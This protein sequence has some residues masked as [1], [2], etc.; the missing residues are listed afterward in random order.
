LTSA[1][2]QPYKD[3]D[4][5][6]SMSPDPDTLR[7]RTKILGAYLREVRLNANETIEACA[8]F[9]GITPAEME[10]FELGEQAISLPELELLSY[11][12]KVPLDQLWERQDIKAGNGEKEAM[13]VASLIHL[14]HRIIGATL[15]QARTEAGISLEELAN[16]L[17]LDISKIEAYELGTE[18][19]PLPILESMTGILNR[20]IRD[21]QDQ[22]G[23]IGKWNIQQRALLD[24]QSL[25]LEMQTFISK[26]INRPYLDL[27]VRLSEM[28]VER[29]R[30]VAEGLLEIT[31]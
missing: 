13:D 18:P 27:A 5:E 4:K 10:Q 30:A 28:S 22:K 12:L 15:K 20:S 24:F 29:L 1:G 17:E 2:L 9:L 21:F 14:R 23:F 11:Y 31:Y 25:P 26:P 7:L 3:R 16:R 19:L 6:K 8:H